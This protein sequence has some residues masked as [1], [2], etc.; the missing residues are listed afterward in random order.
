MWLKTKGVGRRQNTLFPQEININPYAY[1]LVLGVSSSCGALLEDRVANDRRNA[2]I[3]TTARYEHGM[4]RTEPN[5]PKLDRLT[6][7]LNVNQKLKA[8]VPSGCKAPDKFFLSISLGFCDECS[9][10]VSLSIVVSWKKPAQSRTIFS[11]YSL[12]FSLY[13]TKVIHS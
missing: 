2:Y 8:Y 12:I 1:L 7:L 10:A 13:S 9:C 4:P 3:F 5:I 6:V 11:A